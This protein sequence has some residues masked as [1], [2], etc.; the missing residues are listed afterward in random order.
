MTETKSKTYVHTAHVHNLKS[1]GAV[2]PIIVDLFSPRSVLDVGCGIGTWLHEFASVGVEVFGIDGD[3]VDR[4]QL[5]VFIP[6]MSFQPLDLQHPFNLGKKF[7]LVISLEVA[8]HLP[9]LSATSF[10]H[11][12]CLHA[13]VIL[14]SAAVPGQ[15]GQNHLNEQWLLYWNEKFETEG[16]HLYDIIRPVIWDNPEVDWWY[17]Q[18]MV[19]FAK[20]PV[21]TVFPQSPLQHVIHPELFQQH[22]NYIIYLQQYVHELECKLYA[23]R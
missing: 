13:D 19:V 6:L 12:L 17:K 15:G 4:E 23:E 8:E 22:L 16:Y 11:S 18:N 2:V 21:K 14:F 1:P 5:E 9:E 10:I 20:Y 7:D 3:F